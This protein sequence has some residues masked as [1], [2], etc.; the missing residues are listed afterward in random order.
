MYNSSIGVDEAI[1]SAHDLGA[2]EMVAEVEL[3]RQRTIIDDFEK[4][5][6]LLWPTIPGKCG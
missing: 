5:E 4:L 2:G 6:T 1:K 3:L